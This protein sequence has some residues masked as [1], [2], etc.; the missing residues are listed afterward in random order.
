MHSSEKG[1]SNALRNHVLACR[2]CN[3]AKGSLDVE[4]GVRNTNDA[5]EAET[6][7]KRIAKNEKRVRSRA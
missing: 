5:D 1:G 2:S 3:T 6:V 7:I 4:T